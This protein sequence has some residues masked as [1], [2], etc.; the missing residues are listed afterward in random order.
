MKYLPLLLL[1]CACASHTAHIA[2][3]ANEVRAAAMSAREH[4]QAAD[5]QLETVESAAADVHAE[6]GYVSDDANPVV[7][8]L[9]YGSFIAGFAVIGGV[10]YLVKTKL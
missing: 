5:R 3:S 6:L 2:A 1:L 7:E 9:R 4:I 10:L 8:A